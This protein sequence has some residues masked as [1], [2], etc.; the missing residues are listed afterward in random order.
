MF[1]IHIP[2]TS[3]LGR[4]P[5]PPEPIDPDVMRMDAQTYRDL[6]VFEGDGGAPSLYDMFANTRTLGGGK[7]LKARMR[8]PFSNPDKIRA[9]QESIPYILN[10]RPGFEHIPSDLIT[11]EVEKYLGAGLP[12]VTSE[13]KW[14]VFIGAL[15]VRF[16][17][18]RPYAQITRGVQR[19]CKLIRELRALFAFPQLAANTRGEIGVYLDELR[20]LVSRPTFDVIPKTDSWDLSPWTILELDRVLRHQNREAMDRIIELC[21]EVDALVA[22]ADA[23]HK[24]G[25]VMPELVEGPLFIEGEGLINL[26]VEDPVPNP[27]QMD[28]NRRMLFLTGPNMAG[29]TT[30]LRS[31]AAAVYLSQLGMGVPAKWYRFSPAECMYSSLTVTDSV[32]GGVSFFRAEALRVKA[33]AE[34]VMQGRRVVALMDEPFKGTNVKDALDASQAVLERFAEREGLFL[35]SSHLIE[36]GDRME[37]SSQVD[38]RHFEAT[39]N[40]EGRLSFEYTIRDGVSSQR[41]GMRVLREEGIFELLDAPVGTV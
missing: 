16:G 25:L 22:M 23:S 27:V 31:C 12:L 35:V 20:E 41:L 19:G 2:K 33:V 24:F 4:L 39:E 38:C 13:S 11:L 40:A 21:Y 26:F 9:V 28:Q 8:K 10:Y 29:K 15:E 6:E 3:M 5:L 18:F 37:A 34:A 17:D 7:V 36:L 1:K 32:R 30:Y 14:E